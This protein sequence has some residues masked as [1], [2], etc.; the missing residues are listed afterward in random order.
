MFAPADGFN[1]AMDRTAGNLRYLGFCTF[2]ALCV[3]AFEPTSSAGL[4]LPVRSLFWVA[5]LG[6]GLALCLTVKAALV[7]S[8]ITLPPWQLAGLAGLLAT[9]PYAPFAWWLEHQFPIDELDSLEAS[10]PFASAV[11]QEWSDLV[12]PFVLT[13]IAIEWLMSLVRKSGQPQQSQIAAVESSPTSDRAAFPLASEASEYVPAISPAT[14]PT[15]NS[16]T[17]RDSSQPL[18]DLLPPELGS[19]I[20]SVSAEEHY[21]RVRTTRGEALVRCSFGKAVNEY[22]CDWN[23][24]QV[25]RSHWINIEHARQLVRLKGQWT[26]IT[27]KDDHIPVSRR[28][29]SEVTQRLADHAIYARRLPAASRL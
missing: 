3:A 26:C 20:T 25:H 16:A 19:E 18:L 22:L 13:W 7:R 4:N 5:H 10:V 23:G 2:A 11:V 29:R 12:A 9:L 28:K 17:R 6:V 14:S 8:P 1:S 15:K 27:G 24:I 21:L